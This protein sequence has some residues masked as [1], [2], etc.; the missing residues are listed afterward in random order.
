LP[1]DLPLLLLKLRLDPPLVD[2]TILQF[3]ADERAG[4]AAETAAD[5]GTCPRGAYC[6]AN[7]R[8]RRGAEA[9]TKKGTLFTGR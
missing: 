6:G 8:T 3:V 7:N 4:N 2:F 1:L 5:R 9:A